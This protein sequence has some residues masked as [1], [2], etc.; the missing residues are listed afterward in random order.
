MSIVVS[1]IGF[2]FEL[3]LLN[4]YAEQSEENLVYKQKLHLTGHVPWVY[5]LLVLMCIIYLRQGGITIHDHLFSICPLVCFF[6]G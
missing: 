1:Y 2:S 6:T 5:Y 3:I 4:W